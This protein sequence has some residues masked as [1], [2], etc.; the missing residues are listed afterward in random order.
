MKNFLLFIFIWLLVPAAHS[1]SIPSFERHYMAMLNGEESPAFFGGQSFPQPDFC[2]IDND[3][4]FDLF[5]P[6]MDGFFFM[7]NTGSAV[8]AQWEAESE[9]YFDTGGYTYSIDFADLDGDGDLDALIGTSGSG[10][11]YA[12]N[13]GTSSAPEWAEPVE[14]YMGIDIGYNWIWPEFADMDND[15]DQDLV[16]GTRSSKVVLVWNT[17]TAAEPVFDHPYQQLFSIDNILL[18]DIGIA[19][20]DG[21]LDPDLY[22]G[23]D[24]NLLWLENTGTPE[25]YSFAGSVD[26]FESDI[27]IHSDISFDFADIDDDGDND[28]LLHDAHFGGYNLYENT[29][30]S[31]DEQ[32]TLSIPAWLGIDNGYHGAV[33]LFD[34]DADGDLDLLYSSSNSSELFNLIENTGTA[35]VAAWEYAINSELDIVQKLMAHADMDDDGDMEVIFTSADQQSLQ[36]LVNTGTAANGHWENLVENYGGI[37]FEK[38][39]PA[40]C[41]IDNDGDNDL[42]AGLADSRLAFVENTGSAASAAWGVPDLDYQNI[43]IEEIRPRPEFADMDGDG[44]FDLIIGGYHFGNI[45]YYENTGTASAAAFTYRTNRLVDL[46]ISTYDPKPKVGDIDGDGDADLFIATNEGGVYFY[47]NTTGDVPSVLLPHAGQKLRVYPNPAAAVVFIED[48][49]PDGTAGIVR[50]YDVGG[51][52]VAIQHIVFE[53]GKAGVDLQTLEPGTYI[54]RF[55]SQAAKVV[56]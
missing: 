4:D 52:Q 55:G 38:L 15:G 26:Y 53:G 48:G 37:T 33:D 40:L 39:C 2:D 35:T 54:M 17:G 56:R 34:Y 31:S 36:M 6:H 27:Q 22:V 30:T 28:L 51:R 43:V 13:T 32:W 7:R 19:D 16:V 24:R 14:N 10:F 21:D 1:Q 49:L 50:L 18:T 23:T 45:Y 42:F 41:D 46:E 20:N 29:G 47:E 9:R 25:S 5:I 3:G 11:W 12:E 8:H 44:D